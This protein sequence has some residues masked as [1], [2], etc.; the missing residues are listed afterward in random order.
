MKWSK[1]ITVGEP[2]RDVRLLARTPALNWQE[3][4]RECE[5][6]AYDQGCR[7]GEK[8]SAEQLLQQ[9]N[10]MA[11]LQNGIVHSMKEM[12]PKMAHEVESALIQL[13]LE[14]AKKIVGGMPINAKTVE[15]VVREA[16]EQ[17]QDTAEISVQLHP[18]DIALL[19]KHKSP[20]L[21]DSP[22]TGPL[23]FVPSAEVTRGGC[24]VQTRFGLVD[25]S[26]ETKLELLRKA[27]N[28]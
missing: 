24:I 28:L 9:S 17:V 4:V 6:A 19:R 26:R 7:E 25:A 15:K 1:S 8:R 22:E 27:V 11:E 13:A 16:L 10:E 18:E 12:L 23:R 20:L 2:F 5:K 3:H 14:S 21:K